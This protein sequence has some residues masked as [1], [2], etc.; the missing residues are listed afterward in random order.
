MASLDG[1]EFGVGVGLVWMADDFDILFF[2][3]VYNRADIKRIY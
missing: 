1:M 2:V 3:S